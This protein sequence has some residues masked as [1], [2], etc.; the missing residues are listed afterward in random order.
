MRFITTKLYST[1][2]LKFKTVLKHL[3]TL[4]ILLKIKTIINEIKLQKNTKELEL[5]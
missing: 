4:S 1:T 5:L 3:N 2:L